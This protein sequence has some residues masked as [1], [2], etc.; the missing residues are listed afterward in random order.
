MRFRVGSCTCLFFFFQAEDGIRYGRVTGVQ[1]CALPI[2]ALTLEG[3][4][5]SLGHP[6]RRRLRVAEIAEPR[7]QVVRLVYIARE[8]LRQQALQ[9]Q[10]DSRDRVRVEELAQVLAAEQ[11]GEELAVEGQRL[12]AALR[13]RRVALVHEL[14]HVGEEKRRRE[15]RG[16]LGVDRHDAHLARSDRAEE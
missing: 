16:A 14:R 15:R 2:S 6:T 4:Q 12:S 11:L 7:Q 10:L 3:A 1:T 13:E 5:P 8:A 9:L